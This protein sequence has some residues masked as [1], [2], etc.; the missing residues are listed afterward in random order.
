MSTSMPAACYATM[1][2]VH[3]ICFGFGVY[4]ITWS[5]MAAEAQVHFIQQR[6][7][8]IHPT[9]PSASIQEPNFSCWATIAQ[10]KLTISCAWADPE[11]LSKALSLKI[12]CYHPAEV[13]QQMTFRCNNLN[14][15]YS[16]LWTQVTL[17]WSGMCALPI[18]PQDAKILLKGH[19]I[20][21]IDIG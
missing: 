7:P 12:G 20:L 1:H 11:P 19:R 15:F 17:H 21:G 6:D 14:D 9:N 10:P 16:M 4:I 2:I 3:N 18:L 13:L 8:I 5:G